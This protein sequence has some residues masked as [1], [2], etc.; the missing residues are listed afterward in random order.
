MH[1]ST[2][3]VTLHPH[4]PTPAPCTA[5]A[6]ALPWLP[7]GCPTSAPH[8]PN[9]DG[10]YPGPHT[11]SVCPTCLPDHQH[12]ATIS[13]PQRVTADTPMIYAVDVPTP[14]RRAKHPLLA[15]LRGAG[16]TRLAWLPLPGLDNPR[17]LV[18]DHPARGSRATLHPLGLDLHLTHP[19][20]PARVHLRIGPRIDTT[21]VLDALHTTG[22]PITHP[23]HPAPSAPA[24]P[25]GARLLTADDAIHMI[26]IGDHATEHQPDLALDVTLIDALRAG[27]I[28][29]ALMPDD[30]LAF[31]PNPHA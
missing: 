7:D 16:F 20:S 31:T 22:H 5:H 18:A 29:A 17:V 11:A 8:W 9:R 15:I 21:A 26:T 6:F 28:L 27:Q 10:H 30:R 19:D 25:P 14:T 12:H 13:D 3:R 2:H 23:T 24:L 1:P 4:T